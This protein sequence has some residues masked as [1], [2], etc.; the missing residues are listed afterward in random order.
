MAVK[1][2]CWST[3]FTK[4]NRIQQWTKEVKNPNGQEVDQLA[5]Y[6]YSW[7]VGPETTW[8]ISS[9][10]SEQDLNSG[11]PDFKSSTLPLQPH[12]LLCNW[13]I[14][15]LQHKNA[16]RLDREVHLNTSGLSG[17]THHSL[18]N[19]LARILAKTN[20]GRNY[21]ADP[22]QLFHKD[23]NLVWCISLC[24]KLMFSIRQGLK[25]I[26]WIYFIS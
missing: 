5:T 3:Y 16:V 7:A 4:S 24:W 8:N 2:W 23:F 11:S 17:Y 18:K 12:Y 15:S 14:I 6:K 1:V 26:L 25:C 19:I 21:K 22:S 13:N 10:W 9:R 20:F